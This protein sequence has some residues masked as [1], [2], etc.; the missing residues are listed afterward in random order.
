MVAHPLLFLMEML[1]II[2][3][4]Y[5]SFV[6]AKLDTQ[7]GEVLKE[8]LEKLGMGEWRYIQGCSLEGPFPYSSISAL[9][10]LVDL[11]ISD[12]KGG[13]YSKF[14]QLEKMTNLKKLL[15]RNCLIHGTIP[16]YIGNMKLEALDLSF[17][18]FSGRIP[19]SF[20]QLRN[21]KYIY[22]T[23]NNLSG[24][25]P[26]WV[27]TSTK[28]VD[29]SYNQFIWD[30]S[31]P[32]MCA[33]GFVNMVQSHSSAINDGT[34]ILPCLRKDFPCNKSN[35]QLAYSMFI[36]CGGEEVYINNTLKYKEDLESKLTPYYDGGNWAF[37]S[38]GNFLDDS[39]DDVYIISNTS[40]LHNISTSDTK[41]FINART[42]AISLT[43]YGLCLLNGNYN[44]TLYFAEIVFSQDKSYN[45][46]GKRVFDVYVQ[47]EL[48]IKDFDIVKEA[49]GTGRAVLKKY[50]VNVQ[51]NTLK[52]QLYWAGKGTTCIPKRGSYGPII[53]AISVEPNFKPPNFGKKTK[54]GLIAGT[55][56]GVLFF[57]VLII[58]ILWRKGYIMG[59]KTADSAEL[60]ASD[61]EKKNIF[62]YK[63]IQAATKN[64]DPLNK[65]GKGGFGSVFKGVLLDGTIIAV[66]QLSDVSKQGARE[67]VNEIGILSAARHPNLIR[68]YGCCA[69]GSQLLLIYEYMENNS[70]S[71]ALLGNEKRLKAKLTWPVRFKICLGI[72]RGLVYL[73][74]ES[75]LKI[76]HRD[77]KASNVLLDEDFNAKISDFGLAKL[78]DDQNTHVTTRVVGTM[79]YMAPEYATRGY[80]TPKADVYGFGIVA[81]EIVSGISVYTELMSDVKGYCII[82]KA[83]M[84]KGRDLLKMVD[85]D[86][87][88]DYSSEKALT[89]LNVAVLCL[90]V[91]AIRPTMS[92]TCNMLEGKLNI[93]DFRRSMRP[94][95]DQ[96]IDISLLW[97]DYK[98][99]DTETGASTST[100]SVFTDS[101]VTEDFITKDFITELP[102]F[103]S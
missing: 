50:T 21:A 15:L 25:I 90:E 43:Y 95:L 26:E 93:N 13:A 36:N 8:I 86:L 82:D 55:I 5:S 7:E 64:F 19:Q 12:L 91:S 69:E 37:S 63:Q 10:Q 17:N 49:G 88:S 28:D 39:G 47:G 60:R 79:F 18:N 80:L 32:H 2:L 66:K 27:F 100:Q 14:P 41:L 102:T 53:S 74:E 77:I 4:L 101:F 59:G 96:P 81:L 78:H 97:P 62:T 1:A 76:I 98:R 89:V 31:H 52:I 56:G 92:Q 87:G 34:N 23:Q 11:R 44:L 65:L 22:L 35:D 58:S 48:K 9:T 85:K 20:S 84:L 73:H 67:F 72:A 29:V 83:L 16:E 51:K 45:S 68:I 61:L 30:A 40:N 94:P 42:A 57:V 3:I 75:Q 6:F 46:L 71:H 24:T 70:L 99:N 33:Q 54:V 103:S 38:T